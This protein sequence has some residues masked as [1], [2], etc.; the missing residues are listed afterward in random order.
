MNAE[1]LEPVNAEGLKQEDTYR[2][3]PVD[4][5]GL[6]KMDAGELEPMD[7]ECQEPADVVYKAAAISSAPLHPRIFF[8]FYNIL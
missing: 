2:P 8:R 6:D 7:A 3:E 4:A 5:E 1:R